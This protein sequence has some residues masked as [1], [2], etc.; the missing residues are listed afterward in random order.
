MEENS[1]KCFGCNHYQAYY[2]RAFCNLFRERF[3]YCEKQGKIV[4]ENDYCDV[5]RKRRVSSAQYTSLAMGAISE[6]HEKVTIVEHMLKEEIAVEKLNKEM[7][8]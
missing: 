7:K 1:K 8:K 3:G 5:W 6:I 4:K 2:T